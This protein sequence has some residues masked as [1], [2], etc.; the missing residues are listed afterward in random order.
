MRIIDM[1]TWVRFVLQA[2]PFLSLEWRF[3]AAGD[4]KRDGVAL[5]T[6]SERAS[7]AVTQ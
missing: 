3:N 6:A 4:T 2:T 5:I 1:R 7:A